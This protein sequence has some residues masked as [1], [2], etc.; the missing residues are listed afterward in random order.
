MQL[1]R[2][3]DPG[4]EEDEESLGLEALEAQRVLGISVVVNTRRI[5]PR[6]LARG[7]R[8]TNSN[9]P[10]S[11]IIDRTSGVART[12]MPLHIDRRV[13]PLNPGAAENLG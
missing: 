8:R 6:T 3:A 12:F 5:A 9:P 13:A 1:A 10:F 11:R 7:E 2:G 4:L